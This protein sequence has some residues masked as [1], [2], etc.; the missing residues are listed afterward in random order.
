MVGIVAGCF[1]Q[2]TYEKWL[3]HNSITYKIVSSSKEARD[4][5]VM[6]FC[7]GPDFGLKPERDAL[8]KEIFDFCQAH[9]VPIFGGCR[10]MQVIAHFLGAELIQDLG[11]L[12]DI[13]KA[14]PDK[15]SRFHDIVLSNGQHWRV[16]SR[17]HQAVKCPPFACEVSAQAED[18]TWEMMVSEDGL[19]FLVQCHPEMEEMWGSE[20]ERASIDYL[21]KSV[22]SSKG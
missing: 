3:Q 10:G 8:D 11:E 22:A 9:H 17:H 5:D 18:G 14:M 15:Q 1:S 6:L 20:V 16:N 19:F 12:N 13:H 7:G 2:D 21:S 4:V